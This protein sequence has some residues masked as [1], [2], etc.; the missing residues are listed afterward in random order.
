MHSGP[1]G[2]VVR[3]YGKGYVGT[4]W[5]RPRT[6]VVLSRTS[7]WSAWGVADP[8]HAEAIVKGMGPHNLAWRQPGE[9][10]DG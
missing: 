10:D 8:K 1:T 3:D 5:G 6:M 9:A 7:Y 4:G 2:V